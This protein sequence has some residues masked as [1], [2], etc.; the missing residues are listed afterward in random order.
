MAKSLAAPVHGAIPFDATA[1]ARRPRWLKEIDGDTPVFFI[2]PHG[3]HA[4]PAARATVNPKVND[5]HTA[6]ITRELAARL[7]AG[8]LINAGMDRNRLDLN[9]LSQ[10]MSAAPWMLELI[11][12]R[13]ERIAARHGRAVVLLIHGWNVIEPRVD[14]GIGAKS[15]PAGGLLPGRSAHV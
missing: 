8:A 9:R 15:A 5:L 6:E 7:G 1:A 13:L 2:A 14:V 3:G 10:V 11:A 12:T 4:G